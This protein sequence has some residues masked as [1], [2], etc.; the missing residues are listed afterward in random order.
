MGVASTPAALAGIRAHV[1]GLPPALLDEDRNGWLSA[2]VDRVL[3]PAERSDYCNLPPS[4]RRRLQ[5]LSGRVAAK[6]VVR[7]LLDDLTGGPLDTAAVEIR[8]DDHGAPQ[9]SVRGRQE[10]GRRIHLSIAHTAEVAVAMCSA[11]VPV[12]GVGIDVESCK[13]RRALERKGLTPLERSRL[14]ELPVP[15]RVETALRLWCAKEAAAKALGTG[16]AR[17]GG[18]QSIT[19]TVLD[20]DSSLLRVDVPRSPAGRVRQLIATT[21]RFGDLIVA[22]V[23]DVG[24]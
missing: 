17:I 22:T 18:A 10:L 5:W 3:T 16:L 20:G 6:E 14:A 13:I 19:V 7:G 2:L 24:V 9:V 1:V 8:P 15:V 11:D 12:R 4:P 21:R 23:V